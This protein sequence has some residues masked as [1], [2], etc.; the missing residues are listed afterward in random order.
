MGCAVSRSDMQMSIY[1]RLHIF[2]INVHMS[3]Y[4]KHFSGQSFIG[5]LDYCCQKRYAL[6][7]SSLLL[8][9]VAKNHFSKIAHF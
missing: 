7:L 9:Y 1:L 5:I 3:L 6:G 8:L 2:A 4:S